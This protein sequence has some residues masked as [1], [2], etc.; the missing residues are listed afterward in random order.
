MACLPWRFLFGYTVNPIFHR[1]R[2][3]FPINIKRQLRAVYAYSFTSA[4]G[5]TN[6]VWVTLLA[7]RGYS[8]AQIGLAEGIFHLVSLLAEVPSG[9]AADLLGRRRTLAASGLMAC[10][11]ALTMAFGN[12]FAAVCLAMGASALSYNLISGTQEAIT[13]DSLKQAGRSGEYL[14]VDA[15]CCQLQTAGRLLS[16]CCSMLSGVLSFVGFYLAD[17]VVGLART[18]AAVFLK[19]PV[20]TRTQAA[21][22]SNPLR[23]IGRRLADHVRLT[24]R[25][26]TG[27]PRVALYIAANAVISLPCYLSYMYLQQ[28]LVQA[29]F[30]T[31]WLGL[32]MLLTEAGGVLGVALGRRLR[33]RRLGPL[34][35]V[36]ALVCGVSTMAA[37]AALVAGAIAGGA[38]ISVSTQAWFLHVQQRLNDAYPSDQRATL[39]S[40]D[41]MAY[42]LLMIPASPLTGWVGDVT[43][44][45]GAGLVA[46]GAVVLPSAAA[47]GFSAMHRRGA[48]KMK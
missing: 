24:A 41:S 34:Y 9:V 46:L 37:G 28:R 42:S 1:T 31:R 14:Q 10:G 23:G 4:L 20:V 48:V 3:V 15:N 32:P 36:C 29:G 5:V 18:V 47:A 22:Q 43:G 27:S 11:S 30:P 21:R 13:Y 16:D 7:A 17:A 38:L 40:V 33:V 45:A 19:E 12:S 26:L 6:A 39:V 25:F 8:L 44:H 2:T 35:A